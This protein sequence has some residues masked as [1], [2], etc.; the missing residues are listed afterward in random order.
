MKLARNPYEE[1]EKESIP[2]VKLVIMC[3]E[4]IIELLEGAEKAIAEKNYEEK[5]RLLSKA[6]DIITELICA[7]DFKRGKQIAYGLNNI[8]LYC[9]NRIIEA[10]RE[11]EPAY[12]KE[13][14]PI[15]KDI[16]EAWKEVAKKE[17]EKNR[18]V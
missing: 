1:T 15:L 9:L 14:I 7:L 11:N 13:I 12:L 3:Y 18:S 4:K 2:K 17:L 8:Y 10:D 16:N 6:V 5:S